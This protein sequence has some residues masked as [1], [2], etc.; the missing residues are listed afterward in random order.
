V[1]SLLGAGRRLHS[2]IGY[3]TPIEFENLYYRENTSQERPLLGEPA[4]H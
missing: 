4:L 2:S 1:I 3:L